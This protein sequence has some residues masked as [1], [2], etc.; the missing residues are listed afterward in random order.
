MDVYLNV[1]GPD[2]GTHDSDVS[3]RPGQLESVG[4]DVERRLSERDDLDAAGAMA[5][6][7]VVV[8]DEGDGIF[9]RN[10]V[11]REVLEVSQRVS[12]VTSEN[13]SDVPAELEFCHSERRNL[14]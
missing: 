13:V 5:S 3:V 9:G 4:H 12:V 8:V 6:L 14:H 11:R 2:V 1:Q 7:I 10:K